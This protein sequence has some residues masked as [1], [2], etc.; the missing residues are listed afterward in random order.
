[1][2]YWLKLD[3]IYSRTQVNCL[4]SYSLQVQDIWIVLCFPTTFYKTYYA[5]VQ[6]LCL[7]HVESTIELIWLCVHAQVCRCLMSSIQ[8]IYCEKKQPVIL[9]SISDLGTWLM[10]DKMRNPVIV[11]TYFFFCLLLLTLTCYCSL[12]P[13]L[14]RNKYRIIKICA[15]W[16]KIWARSPPPCPVVAQLLKQWGSNRRA[17]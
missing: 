8:N 13:F 11:G 15:C 16:V 4:F 6:S 7:L 14:I 2:H 12:M 1:M 10:A 5:H 17:N 9:Q 3:E